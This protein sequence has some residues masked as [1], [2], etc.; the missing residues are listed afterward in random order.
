MGHVVNFLGLASVRCEWRVCIN[1]VL[2]YLFVCLLV[3]TSSDETVETPKRQ[4]VG[5]VGVGV[6]PGGSAHPGVPSV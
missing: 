3:R 6:V 1:E 2:Y 5:V 4:N